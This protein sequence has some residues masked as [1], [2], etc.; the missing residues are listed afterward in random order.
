MTVLI[1]FL[2][3]A[4]VAACSSGATSF[5]SVLSLP[6]LLDGLLPKITVALDCDPATV[7]K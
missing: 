5:I 3:L 2:E 1:R 7:A 6:Y 4:P